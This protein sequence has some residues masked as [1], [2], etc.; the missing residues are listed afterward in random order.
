VLQRR[1]DAGGRLHSKRL[2]TIEGGVPWIFRSFIPAKQ[3]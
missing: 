2:L 3:L 1:V